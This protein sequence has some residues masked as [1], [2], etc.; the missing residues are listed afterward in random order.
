MANNPKSLGAS[1]GSPR[2]GVLTASC[3]LRVS[4][5]PLPLSSSPSAL[6]G[7]AIGVLM[8][9]ELGSGTGVRPSTDSANELDC[10]S[11]VL[12][13]GSGVLLILNPGFNAAG[14]VIFPLSSPFTC[15]VRFAVALFNMGV[16][17]FLAFALRIV[18]S[19]FRGVR[20]PPICL[21][22]LS[23]SGGAWN[24]SSLLNDSSFGKRVVSPTSV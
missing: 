4:T 12:A 2:C 8:A 24:D 20:A 14:V 1:H 10:T 11:K 9:L 23:R 6:R 17:S 5:L 13:S 21:N 15:R 3:S 22:R 7:S 18:A 19:G 16:N